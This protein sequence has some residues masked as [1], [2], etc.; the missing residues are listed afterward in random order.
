MAHDDDG[1]EDGGGVSVFLSFWRFGL[2]C[3]RFVFR[4]VGLVL[5]RV[6]RTTRGR[7]CRRL[8]DGVKPRIVY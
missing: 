1:E 7:R 8:S 3:S 6:L 4:A 5:W 2:T